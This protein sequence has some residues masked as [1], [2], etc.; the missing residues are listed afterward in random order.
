M[1]ELRAKRKPVHGHAIRGERT[2]TY[3]SWRCMLARCRYEDRDVDKKHVGRGITVAVRWNSFELFLEDMGERPTGTTLERI[4]NEDGYYPFNCRW[5]TH[6]EQA[7]NRRNS[8]LNYD[9]ALDIAFRMLEGE[10]AVSLA[11]EY[12]ISE[13]LPREIHK[14][15]TWKDAYYAARA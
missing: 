1:S 11:K 3:Q 8:K 6:T 5:A 15:R 12:G 10:S 14:G 9:K 2:I 4:D 13:S 7:R